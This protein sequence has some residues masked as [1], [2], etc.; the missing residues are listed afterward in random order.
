MKS[1]ADSVG[2]WGA[3]GDGWEALGLQVWRSLVC[4]RRT[5]LLRVMSSNSSS[6]V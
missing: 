5:E 2:W 3:L 6:V 1:S 4:Y